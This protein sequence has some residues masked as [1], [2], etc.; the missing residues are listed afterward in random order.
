MGRKAF[1][2]SSLQ[3]LVFHFVAYV[4]STSGVGQT[5]SQCLAQFRHLR[6]NSIPGLQRVLVLAGTR[7]Q[8][9]EEGLALYS[10]ACQIWAEN[11]GAPR[12]PK[13]GHIEWAT[14]GAESLQPTGGSRSPATDMALASLPAHRE[15]TAWI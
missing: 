15:V 3:K 8:A 5:L 4:G 11:F 9:H 12:R 7:G 14:T 13:R 2:N 10:R 1:E 6:N